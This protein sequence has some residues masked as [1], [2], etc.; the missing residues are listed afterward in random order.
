M[1]LPELISFNRLNF[2]ILL[3]IRFLYLLCMILGWW[4]FI[5]EG[6]QGDYYRGIG[7][8]CRR[9]VCGGCCCMG[10]Q[11]YQIFLVT[12]C[13]RRFMGCLRRFMG[14]LRRFI[15]MCSFL[16]LVFSCFWIL[17]TRFFYHFGELRLIACFYS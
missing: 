5:R 17:I 13:L 7:R 11:F 3:W 16:P 2:I 4:S 8:Y 9:I 1:L 12:G 6:W 10:E 15:L 14:C